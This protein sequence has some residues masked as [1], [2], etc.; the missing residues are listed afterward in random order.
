MPATVPG[1]D[2]LWLC[3]TC[4]TEYPPAP[5]PP[6]GPCPICRDDRQYLPPGGQVWTTLNQ[7]RADGHRGTVTEVEPGL[8][9]ITITPG[10]GIG[11]CP[12]L[13]TTPAGN[14]LF[15]VPAYLDDDLVERVR[16]LGG[17]AAIAPSHPHHLGVQVEWSRA[18]ADA[19][20]WV[21]ARD[22]GWVQRPDPVIRTWD[23]VAAPVA[24]VTLHRVGGHFPG[25][26]VAHWPAGADGRGVLLTGDTIAPVPADGWVTFMRSYPNRIPLSAA[27]VARMAATVDAL[28]FDRIYDEFERVVP[29]DARAAVRRSAE[30][31]VAWVRG[32]H[33]HLT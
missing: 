24:G 21:N 14:L 27:V 1:T 16:A 32:D 13:V 4:A 9:R 18:F 6:A 3:R 7:L 28:A 19:P 11:Q 17:I 5:T 10:I 26:A 31:Y 20:I 23:D 2:P 33:D 8:H 30:R 25:S 22:V 29:Q 15:D 12:L